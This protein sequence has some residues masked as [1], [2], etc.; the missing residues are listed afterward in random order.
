MQ[1]SR[2]IFLVPKPISN[3]PITAMTPE[4]GPVLVECIILRSGMASATEA[5]LGGFFKNC[6]N[7]TSIWTTPTEMFHPQPPTPVAT[8]NTATNSIV[9]GTSKKKIQSNRHDIL[10]GARQKTTKPFPHILGGR[11]EKY[12]GIFHQT[13]PNLDPQNYATNIFETNK[14]RHGKLKIPMY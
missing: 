4:N 1:Q 7:P 10:L 12:G 13:P 5:E 14:K 9:N 3:T 11:K 2:Y 8:D 6:Q